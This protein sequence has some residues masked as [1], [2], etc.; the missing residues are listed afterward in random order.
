MDETDWHEVTDKNSTTGKD[1]LEVTTNSDNDN[2]I[3][4]DVE[5]IQTNSEDSFIGEGNIGEIELENISSHKNVSIRGRSLDIVTATDTAHDTLVKFDDDNILK[6]APNIT[7]V[8]NS[9]ISEHS[10]IFSYQFL[11]LVFLLLLFVFL[12]PSKPPICLKQSKIYPHRSS[13][14]TYKIP[15]K[16]EKR[17]NS[18][19]SKF[20]FPKT[21]VGKYLLVG[22]MGENADVDLESDINVTQEDITEIYI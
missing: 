13:P 19:L 11:F 9:Q 7:I 10:E 17:E 2:N 20:R 21:I 15:D 5:H 16:L 4:S 12:L 22:S 18:F 6:A 3:T 1:T 14:Q 8:Q